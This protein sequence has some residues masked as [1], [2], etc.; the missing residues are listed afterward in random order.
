M[1]KQATSVMSD[2]LN[3]TR[4]TDL[5]PLRGMLADAVYAEKVLAPR[6]DYPDPVY[7]CAVVGFACLTR[8]SGTM[9]L[10]RSKLPQEQMVELSYFI[11]KHGSLICNF[12][13]QGGSKESMTAAHIQLLQWTT[14]VY[15]AWLTM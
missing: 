8:H 6:S 14:L 9:A 7:D 1:Q 3:P 11:D 5:T 2:V 12:L 15:T 10:L 13:L 4:S